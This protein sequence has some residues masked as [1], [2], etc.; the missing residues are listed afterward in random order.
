VW[1]K[2]LLDYNVINSLHLDFQKKVQTNI[3]KIFK[4]DNDFKSQIA[5]INFNESSFSPDLYCLY[6]E[7]LINK[8]THL[9][10]TG[11]KLFVDNHQS[12]TINTINPN[13]SLADNYIVNNKAMHDELMIF[14]FPTIEKTLATSNKIQQ[15]LKLLEPIK[16][17]GINSILLNSINVYDGSGPIPTSAS[18]IFTQGRIYV[19]HVGDEY[20]I[21]YYLDMLIHEISHQYFNLINNLY[22]VISDYNETYLSVARNKERPI[23]GI[24][25]AVFVLYRLITIYPLAE[26]L[27]KNEE[28]DYPDN[29]YDTHLYSRFFEIPFN[30]RYRMSIYLMKFEISMNQL[31]PSSNITTLGKELLIAMQKKVF[32]V[33][34]RNSY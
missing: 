25:H 6:F 3:L 15:A 29:N 20:P 11:V 31:L 14:N 30:Y 12:P 16:I 19:K 13:N 27:L 5:S 23:Y 21:F 4:L 33:K 1:L 2:N 8:A 26:D 18:T 32:A 10:Q 28:V 24:F 17:S 34:S 7:S 22:C 9:D